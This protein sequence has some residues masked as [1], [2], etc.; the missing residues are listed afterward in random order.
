MWVLG[1]KPW[2]SERAATDLNH[3]AISTT[4]GI[5]CVSNTPW[6][7]LVYSQILI[8]PAQV[9]IKTA[10]QGIEKNLP[11]IAQLCSDCAKGHLDQW[12][13]QLSGH[14]LFAGPA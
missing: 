12:L 8:P 13:L 6:E 11:M 9:S 5:Y 4:L 7:V 2:S 14:D 1:P 10:V 3:R